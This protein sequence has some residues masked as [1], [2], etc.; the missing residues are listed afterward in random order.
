MIDR[1]Y[2]KL[3]FSFFMALFMSGIM[4]LVI[5]VFNL[6]FISNLFELWLKSWGFAF[7]VAF[8]TIFAISPFVHK[9]VTAVVKP[10]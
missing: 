7:S 2:H 8:P 5:T 3:V 9:I 6:G 1:K 4:S 10:Q